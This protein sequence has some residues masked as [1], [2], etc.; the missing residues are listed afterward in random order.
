VTIPLSP[1][2]GPQ[3]SD[4]GG[5][6]TPPWRSWFYQLYTYLTAQ[7]TSGGGI[8]P[9]TRSIN[10][11]APIQGGGDLSSDRTLSLQASGITNALL[12][13]MA[14]NTIKGNNTGGVAQPLDLTSAQA[15]ALL[16]LFTSTLQGLTPASGGGSN[17][18]LRSDATWTNAVGGSFSAGTFLKT[19]AV[20]VA[21]LPSAATAGLG[22]RHFVTDATVTTFASIVAGGGGN[23]VPVYSDA[24]NWRIG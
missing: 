10:T 20:V 4:K 24:T 3:V 7:G 9:V 2:P 14:A 19:G 15:T 5:T 6:L 22:A 8:V 17:N 12:A 13:T 16:A 21:S 11:T 1:V 18:L 23:N